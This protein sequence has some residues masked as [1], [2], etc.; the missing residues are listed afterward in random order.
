M[1]KIQI[2]LSLAI[3]SLADLVKKAYKVATGIENNAASFRNIDPK[4]EEIRSKAEELDALMQQKDALE[5]ELKA[6]N[7][8]IKTKSQVVG[9]MLK[10]VGLQVQS[11]ANWQQNPALI[12]A[13]GYDIRA[14]RSV[15]SI[16]HVPTNLRLMEVDKT[17]GM[18]SIA[19]DPVAKARNYGLIWA[20]GI[21]PPTEWAKQPML[22]VTSSRNKRIVFER[23]QTIWVRVKAFGPNNTESDWSDV[24]TRIVP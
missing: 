21:T 4:P 12:G 13:C 18:L 14:A 16:V 11:E 17:S 23:G 20:Y 8:T 3:M 24:A 7:Q 5:S 1:Q 19:F 22:I 15:T 10:S 9:A 6:L 2:V